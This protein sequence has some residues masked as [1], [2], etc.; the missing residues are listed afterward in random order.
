M[1]MKITKVHRILKFRPATVFKQYIERNSKLRAQTFSEFM[2]DFFKLL[3]NSL[4]GK[5]MENLRKRCN[6]K[7]VTSVGEYL[8]ET[9]K[10]QFEEAIMYSESLFG[11]RSTKSSIVLD[12]PMYLGMSV[13]DLSKLIMYEYRYKQLPILEH[14]IGCKFEV[15]AGDTDSLFL[16]VSNLPDLNTLYKCMIDRK[17]LDTSNF[18][19]G[20]P[21]KSNE[22]KAR[23]GFVKDE[24]PAKDVQTMLFLKPKSYMVVDKRAKNY[25]HTAKGVIK[26][27]KESDV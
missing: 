1:G 14:E 12:K 10:P 9:S 17:L 16:L 21:L 4:Y 24:Y 20:H 3:N 18:P 5:S 7:I 25:K 26:Q 8:E 23:L 11:I 13:L 19:P 2:K 27:V 6:I 15:L 22:L